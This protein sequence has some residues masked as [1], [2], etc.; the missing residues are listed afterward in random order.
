MKNVGGRIKILG[1]ESLA[2]NRIL[3]IA[4]WREGACKYPDQATLSSGVPQEKG[5]SRSRF[6]VIVTWDPE[7]SGL[8]PIQPP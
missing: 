8:Y 1:V 7:N 2:L 3:Y 5:A 6:S 4:R